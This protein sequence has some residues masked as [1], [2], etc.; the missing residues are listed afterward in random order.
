M[1]MMRRTLPI[2]LIAILAAHEGWAADSREPPPIYLNQSGFN[3]G[4]PK[5]FTAP[6]LPDGTFFQVV[7]RVAGK[8]VHEG[9]IEKHIGDFSDFNPQSA[10]EFVVKAGGF[11]S[12]PFR[13]GHGWFERV[14]YQNAVNFMIDSRH[15]VGTYKKPCVGS[16]GWRDDH[17]FAFELRTLVPQYLSNPVAYERMPSQI[18]YPKPQRGLWGA[19]QPYQE[20]APD[21]V[22]LIHWGADVTVTQELTHEFLKG[23]LAYFLYAWP[24]LKR[25]LPEQN[26]RAVLQYVQATWEQ[27]TADRKYPYD[28]SPEHNLFALKT[29]LGTTK[30]ELP[31]GHSVM[32]NLLMYEVAKQC[33]ETNAR[34]PV[35]NLGEIDGETGFGRCRQF[36]SPL[37]RDKLPDAEKFFNAAHRQVQWMVENLDWEDPQTTKGQ[38]MS[39]H[40]TMTGLACFLQLHP[41]RAPAGLRKKINDWARV[42]VRRSNNMWDFRRLTDEGRWT[43]SGDKH[44]MWNE[45][46]N[47]VGFPAC[48][49]A[50]APFVDDPSLRAR[51]HE[52]A[53][54]HMDNCFG[55]NPCGRHFSYDARREIEGCDLGWYSHLPGGIGKLGDVR[56]VLDGAP[57][58]V[59]YPYHPEAGNYGWTEGWV[60]FN[61]AFNL[62]LAYMAKAD[63]ELTLQ[64]KDGAVVVRLRAP[65]NFDYEKRETARVELHLEDGSAQEITLHEESASSAF[66]TGSLTPQEKP[67]SASYG[68]GY[69]ATEAVL[70]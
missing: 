61:T 66:F 7:N 45:P 60:N 50:A 51:L 64:Q 46:G 20:D 65:L 1:T 53:I 38:R 70:E 28:R 49:L 27:P 18:T 10:D 56:F 14:T 15:Y 36:Q 32:P 2:I 62:S 35:P 63:T 23:D 59:H 33:L 25:W 34:L 21:V 5:R 6:T 44:T 29:R 37:R 31:P 54:S 43:P 17:H 47:V 30:G 19:L 57:K 68:Y 48:A 22:K 16:F 55:R 12:F 39:E 8:V 13:I 52:L 3:L 9:T 42:A 26:Y 40:V 11:T 69:L 41:D 58:H 67:V 24:Q 4:K